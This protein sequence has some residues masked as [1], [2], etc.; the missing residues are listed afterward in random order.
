MSSHFQL[1]RDLF[2]CCLFFD[3]LEGSLNLGTAG[4]IGMNWLVNLGDSWPFV[5]KFNS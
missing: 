4:I 3:H 1:M 2:R 5:N